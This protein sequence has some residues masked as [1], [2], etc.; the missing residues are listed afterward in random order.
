[1]PEGQYNTIGIALSHIK[2]VNFSTA[3]EC[4]YKFSVGV[5]VS[6]VFCLLLPS[7]FP[8]N[9]HHTY[10]LSQA[11][12]H[13][14]GPTVWPKGYHNWENTSSVCHVSFHQSFCLTTNNVRHV[15]FPSWE[16]PTG[17]RVF[18]AE[19]WAG[20]FSPAQ[21][22]WE[23]T[24]TSLF[25][26]QVS[27]GQ[28]LAT[29]PSSCHQGGGHK[30]QRGAFSVFF[31]CVSPTSSLATGVGVQLAHNLAWVKVVHMPGLQCRPSSCHAA[32]PLPIRIPNCS[33]HV[34]IGSHVAIFLSPSFG[35][36]ACLS[37]PGM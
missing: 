30:A 19:G 22:N 15:M 9:T 8:T 3:W 18:W 28:G 11:V 23:H 34:F 25:R 20:I 4:K 17:R 16:G 10:T 37:V 31:A 5:P 2:W 27:Q 1:M 14:L 36:V 32:R 24:K 33:A 12:S 21:G 7:W 6:N 29:P 26:S 13:S 35:Q